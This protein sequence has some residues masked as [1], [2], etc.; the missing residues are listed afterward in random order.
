MYQ[1]PTME[2]FGSFRELTQQDFKVLAVDGVF[3]CG[4]ASTPTAGTPDERYSM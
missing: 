2:R 3:V 1:K 4:N